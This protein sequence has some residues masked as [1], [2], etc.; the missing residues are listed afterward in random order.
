M[1]LLSSLLEEIATGTGSSFTPGAGEQIATPMAFGKKRSRKEKLKRL[2]IRKGISEA[3]VRIS[4]TPEKIEQEYQKYSKE[5]TVYQ[6]RVE[7]YINI[8]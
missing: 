4:H 1:D 8:F 2:F 7:R 3:G 6:G 5:L